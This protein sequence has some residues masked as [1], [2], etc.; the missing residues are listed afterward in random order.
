M[1]RPEH[2]IGALNSPADLLI[3]ELAGRQHG[4]VAGRQLRALGLGRRAIQ[5]R[6]RNGR[7]HRVYRDVYAVGHVVETLRARWMAAVLAC[8][9]DA[10]LSHY[11]AGRL[12]GILRGGSGPIHV[13]VPRSR[14]GQAGM[15]VHRVRGLDPRDHGYLYRIPVTSLARTLLDLA[16][17]MNARRLRNAIEHAERLRLFDFDEIQ[18]T[19]ERNPGRRGIPRLLAGCADA[20]EEARHTKSELERLLLDLCA[21]AD[22]PLPAMNVT[23]EAEEVDAHWSGT[24]L[25]A[26]LDSWEWHRT[27][28]AFERDRAKS[29][30]LEAAGYRVVRLTWRQLTAERDATA[31]R[32]RRLLATC[33]I[34]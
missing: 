5:E 19:I 34:R 22:L 33:A 26:E 14:V 25:I 3:A 31:S 29:L 1:G 7:L 16:E 10:V 32:L 8:G 21:D 11:D 4:R 12:R 17:V 2:E 27:R 13:T 24:L 20:L 23:I 30:K 28:G 9:D 18:A 15:I 6:T